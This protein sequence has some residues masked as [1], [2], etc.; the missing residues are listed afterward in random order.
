MVLN[1]VSTGSRETALR[2]GQQLL[3]R[4]YISHVSDEAD[5]KDDGGQFYRFKEQEETPHV[6]EFF[7]NKLDALNPSAASLTSEF[8]RGFDYAA[9][10]LLPAAPASGHPLIEPL[11]EH[12]KNLV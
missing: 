2:L 12:N 9:S 10:Q 3:E 11:D 1:A 6:K 8:A 7:D 5:F 4:G